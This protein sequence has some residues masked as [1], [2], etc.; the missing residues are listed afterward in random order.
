MESNRAMNQ[1]EQVYHLFNLFWIWVG[2]K[3]VAVWLISKQGKGVLWLQFK[4]H[5][6]VLRFRQPKFLHEK[7]LHWFNIQSRSL[8][9][10]KRQHLR[11]SRLYMGH[12]TP[13]A[14]FKS[15]TT[16]LKQLFAYRICI[17]PSTDASPCKLARWRGCSSSFPWSCL[18][19]SQLSFEY[20]PGGSRCDADLQQL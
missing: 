10:W 13:A 15:L 19:L 6:T 1:D 20:Q 17:V 12:F 2:L 5:E 18:F 4:R 14:L 9:I 8:C 11:I 16:C 7:W 3:N